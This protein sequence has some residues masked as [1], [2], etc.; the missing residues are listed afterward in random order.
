MY[1]V[2]IMQLFIFYLIKINILQAEDIGISKNS[3]LQY[4]KFIDIP[5]NTD[6]SDEIVEYNNINI[7]D[8]EDYKTFS[9]FTFKDLKINEYEYLFQRNES[10][11]LLSKNKVDIFLQN[12][13]FVTPNKSSDFSNFNSKLRIKD[14]SKFILN[15]LFKKMFENFYDQEN[16]IGKLP[17]L[18]F[19][20]TNMK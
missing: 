3:E 6:D 20:N 5:Y 2:I 15:H 9:K 12:F 4:K 19:Y 8:K 1:G 10:I 17:N 7:E 14:S 13:T 11:N 16:S 18:Q